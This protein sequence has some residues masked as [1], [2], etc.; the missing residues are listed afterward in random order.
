MNEPD[1]IL[2]EMAKA[3]S[4]LATPD[5]QLEV[6]LNLKKVKGLDLYRFECRWLHKGHGYAVSG[7]AFQLSD[8]LAYG[9]AVLKEAMGSMVILALAKRKLPPPMPP[10]EAGL[11]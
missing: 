10:G 8:V 9:G 1:N 5:N 4:E 11:N 2:I 6:C 7:K 3:A